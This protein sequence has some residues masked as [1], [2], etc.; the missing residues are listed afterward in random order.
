MKIYIYRF[1]IYSLIFVFNSPVFA[2]PDY[3]LGDS[4]VYAGSAAGTPPNIM[5]VFDISK[6]MSNAGSAISYDPDTDYIA[7]YKTITGEDSGYTK[8]LLYTYNNGV[9]KK[10]KIMLSDIQSSD[11]DAYAALRDYGSWIGVLDKKEEYY[12]TGNY[13]CL[14]LEL[15]PLALNDWAAATGYAIG[16]RVDVDIDEDGTAERFVCVQAGT[17]GGTAPAWDTQAASINDGTVVWEPAKS[18]LYAAANILKT[19]ASELG[20]KVRLGVSILN[21]N[22]QGVDILQPLIQPDTE[23]KLNA[24]KAEMDYLASLHVNGNHWQVNEALWD[25]GEYYRGDLSNA[26]SSKEKNETYD[27]PA[28]YWCQ[29]NNIILVTSGLEDDLTQVT[30]NR[31]DDLVTHDANGNVDLHGTSLD[32]AKHLYENL[33]P[34]YDLGDYDFRV[35]THVIQLLSSY[36]SK[37]EETANYGHGEYFLL[38]S[39][40]QLSAVLTDLILSLLEVDSSFVA[41]V[42]PA[43][44]ESRAYSGKRIY[45][46]FF[47]PKNDEPWYGN[48]KKFGLDNSNEIV[49]FNSSDTLVYATD[50]DGYFLTDE[51]VN[52]TVRSF[53]STEMDGGVVEK[54]GVGAL[55]QAGARNIYTYTEATSDLTNAANA[56]LYT[57]K[58]NLTSRLALPIT[59]DDSATETEK[60]QAVENLIKY[61][62]GYDA[63]G[64]YSTDTTA[65]RPWIMGDVMHSKP[66][67]I[68]YRNYNF[69]DANE[70]AVGAARLN[71][72]YVFVGSNDGMLHAFR[73]YDGSESWAFIPP[74]LLGNLQYLTDLTHHY[75]FVD[76][77]PFLYVHDK[78]GDGNIGYANVGK[79]SETAEDDTDEDDKAILIFGLRRGGGTSTIKSGSQGSYYALDITEPESPVLLWQINS[80]STDFS[81][82]AQTWSLARVTSMYVNGSEK[83]VAIFGGGYNTNEDLRYGNTQTFPD[84]TDGT[85]ITS[86]ASTGEGT[87]ASSGS[88]SQYTVDGHGLGRGIYIVEVATVNTDK[89]LNTTSSGTLLWKYTYGSS[90]TSVTNTHMTFSIPSEPLLLDTDNNNYTDHIYVMDTGGQLWRFNV[91]DT[92]NSSNWTGQRIF[93]SN[94]A[95]LNGTDI[96]RKVFYKGTATVNGDDTFI[97]IGTGDREHALNTAVVDRLYVFRDREMVYDAETEGYV[98]NLAYPVDESKL[99]DVT[100]Y[101]Y[102]DAD[103]E[104]L[105]A[106]SDYSFGG[107]TYYGWFVKLNETDHDGEK[108]LASPKVLNNIVLYTTYQPATT[109]SPD[110]CVGQL[111]TGR[112]YALDVETGEAALNFNTENDTTETIGEETE[113]TPV[114]NRSDRSLTLEK[115]GLPPEALVMIDDE[116]GV[117]IKVETTSIDPGISIKPIK[118]IYWMMQ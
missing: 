93:I 99:I 73:D 42:V 79:A 57:N 27:D 90:D 14:I 71:Y 77:S 109:V 103:L 78:D 69:T 44:P 114:L 54:G 45:L 38:E 41:P 12:V 101:T 75:Y 98:K 63:Y 1:L 70:A 29:A 33:V 117:S 10:T 118:E 23:T 95:T 111:G 34:A 50:E 20:D 28:A 116:G 58:D 106:S 86:D 53:W 43:S 89:S 92:A 100:D 48:L 26:I 4:S 13:G 65:Q 96:G 68:N 37:L 49:G 11:P 80:E 87:V 104:K 40:E 76:N 107:V 32:V 17:S 112:L 72:G 25:L 39:A 9:T 3:Y 55:L 91:G 2:G 59:S 16:D 62:H 115:G 84:D 31:V 52:P 51:D 108:V 36:L 105:S 74:D 88:S 21:E 102:S 35:K 66:V 113:T 22:N 19:V 64:T 97:Y 110:P 5:L 6:I 18:A 61:I 85:T 60:N 82:L 83:I 47:K 46:G 67:F 30:N 81:E 7:Q 24:F 56:F 15:S 8:D 94:D